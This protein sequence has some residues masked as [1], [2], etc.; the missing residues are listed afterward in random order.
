MRLAHWR[1]LYFHGQKNTRLDKHQTVHDG[2]KRERTFFITLLS[3]LLFLGPE[4]HLEEIEKLCTDEIIINAAWKG[5]VQ[6]LLEEWQELIL[7]VCRC[8]ALKPKF[9]IFTQT[10]SQSTVMLS[11]NVGFLAVPGVVISTLNDNIT[12]ASEAI[13]FTSP[14]QIASYMS[15]VASIG[16]I[17]IGLLLTRHN[18]SKRNE[19]PAGAVSEQQRLV[20]APSS[21]HRGSLPTS[22]GIPTRDSARH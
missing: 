11:A 8:T 7:V 13:I 16:S 22:I 2:P 20:I 18:R 5:F 17:V 12:S 6:K 15:M 4:L 3:P 1:F 9:S 21:S 14:A 19:G 10:I